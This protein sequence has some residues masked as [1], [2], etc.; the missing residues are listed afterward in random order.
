MSPDGK[1]IATG[2]ADSKVRLWEPDPP[3]GKSALKRT[4]EIGPPGGLVKQVYWT[5]DGRHLVTLNG[6]GTIYVLRLEEAP[7]A[8]LAASQLAKPIAKPKPPAPKQPESVFDSLHRE[9]IPPYEL[10]VATL[11][12]DKPAP[13]E[14]V[15]IFGDSRMK[16]WHWVQSLAMSLDG[17][18]FVSGAHDG[19]VRMWDRLT[20]RQQRIWTFSHPVVSIALSPD[21]KELAVGKEGDQFCLINL[22]SGKMR[23]PQSGQRPGNFV[24]WAPMETCLLHQAVPARELSC[25]GIREPETRSSILA[26]RET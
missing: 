13:K 8:A 15:A 14:L 25:Y 26:T 5:P 4:I 3:R 24:A 1:T 6:N 12:D 19:T 9:N 11:G 10:S 22:S 7:P 16:H 23:D 21:G 2:A 20:E 18:T 17:N